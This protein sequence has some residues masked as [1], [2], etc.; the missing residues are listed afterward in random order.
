ML[1]WSLRYFPD[2]IPACAGRDALACPALLPHAARHDLSE[3]SWTNL[4]I[5]ALPGYEWSR[6][7]LEFDAIRAQSRAAETPGAGGDRGLGRRPAGGP[8]ACPGTTSRMSRAFSAGSF[9]ARRACRPSR[10]CARDR[11]GNDGPRRGRHPRAPLA[12]RYRAAAHP[13]DPVPGAR[14]HHDHPALSTRRQ[15]PLPRRRAALPH[16]GRGRDRAEGDDPV[17]PRGRARG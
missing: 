4:S 8:A 6:T 14:R 3:V 16:P 17:R 15:A 11:P 2:T 1:R 5:R 12:A 13:R 10:R 9:R 7:P